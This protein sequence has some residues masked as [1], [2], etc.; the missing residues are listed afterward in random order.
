MSRSEKLQRGRFD[1][2]VGQIER[3]AWPIAEALIA[4]GMA[5]LLVVD[6][7]IR[8]AP[9]TH[10]LADF[11]TGALCFALFAVWVWLNGASLDPRRHRGPRHA[12][13]YRERSLTTHGNSRKN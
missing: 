6:L 7:G 12:P 1:R 11:V 2:S 3:S 4:A 5:V 13:T 9:G 8:Q 10:D